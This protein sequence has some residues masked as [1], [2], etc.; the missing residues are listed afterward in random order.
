MTQIKRAI[1]ESSV[2]DVIRILENEPVKNDVVPEVTIVQVMN[3]VSIAHLSIER[4][5]KFLVNESGG[6]ADRVHS[7]SF[8]Y[9]GL[10]QRDPKSAQFLEIAFHDAVQHYRYNPNGINMTHLKSLETYLQATGSGGTFQDIRYW[11]LTQSLDDILLGKINLSLHTELL[12]GLTE[13]LSASGGP[14]RTVTNRVEQAVRE[15]MWP[16]TELIYQPGT[17]KQWSINSYIEWLGG[18]NAPTEALG[19]AIKEDFKIGDDLSKDI[20]I[21]A[22]ETLLKTADPAVRYY[23]DTLNVLTKQPRDLVPCVEWVGSDREGR[24]YVST[25]GGT[26]LGFI[27]RRLDGLWQIIPLSQGLTRNSVKART[28]TDARCYLA[29]QLTIPVQVTTG[30]D[31]RSLRI[32]VNGPNSFG[33]NF[34][35]ADRQPGGSGREL[36]CTYKV[37][38]WDENHSIQD[39]QEIKIEIR[40]RDSGRAIH[41]LQGVV[42]GVAGPEVS[43]SGVASFRMAQESAQG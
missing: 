11:E 20:L 12:H 21:N 29:T 1:I 36:T 17:P 2:E 38:F 33:R 7:L 6:Q 14:M 41:V 9:R 37:T 28:Q 42:Q 19:D 3:R 15:A 5:M 18:Y 8:L 39:N 40:V 35:G 30:G 32:V 22:Y 43:I 34:N 27:E 31:E 26:K 4:A 10:V 13:I 16:S 23:A 25:P 24:G